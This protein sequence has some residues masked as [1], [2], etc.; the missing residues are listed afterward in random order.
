MAD[1]SASETRSKV[2]SLARNHLVS[3]LR[4]QVVSLA[5]NQ[6]VN[7]T[8]ISKLILNITML[9]FDI[10]THALFQIAFWIFH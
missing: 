10:S 1:P 3:F 5:R 9:N 2:V 4:N 8:G 7:I 6:V